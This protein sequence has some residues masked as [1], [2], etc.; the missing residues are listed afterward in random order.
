MKPEGAG[1]A[2]VGN[3]SIRL[4][5]IHTIGPA[6]VCRL[7]LIVEAIDQ[8]G[9]L[10]VQLA[11]AGAGHGCAL[12]L[13]ARAAEEHVVADVALH[14]PDIGRMSLKDI[15]GVEID[16]A[17]VLIGKL[18]Q[19]GNL[20]PKGRSRIA[21]ED[22]N[23]WLAGPEAC[24]P[25]RRLVFKI[26]HFEVRGRAAHTERSAARLRPHGLKGKEEIGGHRHARHDLSELLG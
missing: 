1:L 16:L 18:V 7:D 14:L 22:E 26:F 8:S 6:G 23:D 21:A 13:I 11:H 19:G 17:L 25:Y 20:P 5:Q 4:N 2:F 15:D 10:D 9:E 24:Q 12:L 3:S